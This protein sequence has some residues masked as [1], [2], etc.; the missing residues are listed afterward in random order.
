MLG[1]FMKEE[2][3]KVIRDIEEE[4][5]TQELI[6]GDDFNYEQERNKLMRKHRAFDYAPIVFNLKDVALFNYVDAQHTSVKMSI[7]LSYTFRITCAQFENLYEQ[8]IG[9]PIRDYTQEPFNNLL[10]NKQY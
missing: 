9:Q 2:T 3:S 1:R 5:E 8:F 6:K 10:N 7:G 4:L